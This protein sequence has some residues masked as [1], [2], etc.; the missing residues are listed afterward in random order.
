MC[1]LSFVLNRDLKWRV[2]S[3][4]ELIFYGFLPSAAP[5]HPNMGRVPPTPQWGGC[6]QQCWMMLYPFFFLNDP[7]WYL[8]LV[9][10]LQF[11]IALMCLQINVSASQLERSFFLGPG[12]P[13]AS[14]NTT[15]S[16]M[17]EG[18]IDNHAMTFASRPMT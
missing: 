2:L 3:K 4:A 13:P 17:Q 11:D 15:K 18:I 14:F 7:S 1:I 8:D 16:V 12:V 9:S 6:I 5:L 10:G